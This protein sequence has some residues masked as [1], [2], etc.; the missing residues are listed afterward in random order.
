MAY[1]DTSLGTFSGRT[2]TGQELDSIKETVALFGNLSRTELTHT[3]CEH[4]DW[5]TPSG[6]N[7]WDA[8]SKMLM[9]FEKKGWL[10]LPEKLQKKKTSPPVIHFS[11]NTDPG[12]PTEKT[13]HELGTVQL[14]R[15]KTRNEI[16]LWN[17]YLDRYHYL[18]YKRPF[19]YR[20][21]YFIR[22]QGTLLGC[23]L[24]SGAARAL[25]CRD[26]WI[27]W[28]T[29][30]RQNN[31][32]YIINNSR[33]LIFPWVKV[34]NLASHVLGKAADRAAKDWKKNW[35]F[36]PALME[37]FVDPEHYKGT[38]YTA[39]NWTY[40]GMTTGK[41]LVRKGKTY[42]TQPKKIFVRHIDKNFRGRLCADV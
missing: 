42:S 8:C 3:I 40:I 26:K 18:G 17:E 22:A 41:G 10:S 24:F 7:K 29:T 2:I 28:T 9:S 38:C 33:F 36:T 34:K 11:K 15:A 37:T 13:L 14:V 1:T 21:K 31:L 6:S 19:G 12:T 32:P 35:G 25:T 5:R 4:L 16:K 20:L 23:I 39:A 30:Q 27:G